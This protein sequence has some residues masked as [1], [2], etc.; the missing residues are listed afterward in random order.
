MKKISIMIIAIFILTIPSIIKAEEVLSET[1]KYYKTVTLLNPLEA[2]NDNNYYPSITTEVSEEEYN[3]SDNLIQRDVTVET[4]YKKL[5]VSISKFNADYYR[6]RAIL[7]WKQMPS[8]RSYDVL[9]IGHYTSVQVSGNANFE[10]YYCLSGGSCYTNTSYYQ[11]ITSLGTG[12]MFALPSGSLSTLKQTLIL[13][14][15]KTNP[16]NTIVSQVAV[17]DYAHATSVISYNSA[18]N[19]TVD[20]YGVD[21]GSNFNYYDDMPFAASSWAGT[22]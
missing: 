18:K 1:V 21:V 20:I 17:G 7:N 4:T 9:G 5:T 11:K 13:L 12:V 14:V 2:S 16:A 22:W 19:F 10:E 15:H 6:Y 3:N 8:T